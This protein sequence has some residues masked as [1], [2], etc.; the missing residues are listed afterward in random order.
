MKTIKGPG[1]FLGQLAAE[2]APFNAEE[3]DLPVVLPGHVVARADVD[4]SRIEAGGEHRLDR[5]G[6]GDLLHLQA[7]NTYQKMKKKVI[8]KINPW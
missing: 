6:F 3:A 4:L 1:I 8:E 2:A 7:V 5:F